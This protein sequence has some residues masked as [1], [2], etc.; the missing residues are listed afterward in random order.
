MPQ[1]GQI[2]L[3]HLGPQEADVNGARVFPAIVTRVWSETGV[4]LFV[5]YDG[6]KAQARTSVGSD[7]DYGAAFFTAIEPAEPPQ[8]PADPYVKGM[9][10]PD[11]LGRVGLR[12]YDTLP[13]DVL[14]VFAVKRAQAEAAGTHA[15]GLPG[16]L[17]YTRRALAAFPTLT[18]DQRE[19]IIMNAGSTPGTD[20]NIARWAFAFPS[21][22]RGE[23]GDK[24]PD[25]FCFNAIE[26]TQEDEQRVIDQMTV[27][28]LRDDGDPNDPR[29]TP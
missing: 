5:F 22:P 9:T 12:Y 17:F 29:F 13:K 25:T 10:E 28:V 15:W 27:R 24:L 26:A 14:E 23:Y 21:G 19:R 8:P 1:L 4:N 2:V 7:P 20:F 3:F 6:A 11:N 16:P 18:Q